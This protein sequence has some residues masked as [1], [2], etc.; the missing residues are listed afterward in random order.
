MAVGAKS[1]SGIRSPGRG[2]PGL[3]GWRRF[4][5]G[6]RQGAAGT[7]ATESHPGVEEHASR[8]EPVLCSEMGAFK[9][10]T[11]SLFYLFIDYTWLL[12]R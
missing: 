12:L 6:A 3:G 1:E 8:G 2:A 4:P 11:F 10:H 5:L 9:T 7:G